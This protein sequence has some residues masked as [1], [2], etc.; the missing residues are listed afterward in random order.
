MMAL[1]P[2]RRFSIRVGGPRKAQKQEKYG[3]FKVEY[4][5]RRVT[6]Y[7]NDHHIP[8][9]LQAGEYQKDPGAIRLPFLE[10]PYRW[11]I[12]TTNEFR[13]AVIPIFGCFIFT[14]VIY[15]LSVFMYEKEEN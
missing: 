4:A 15:N 13:N 1:R 10:R 8:K 5:D 9:R 14:L 6:D 3:N 11:W 7:V 2:F 12:R